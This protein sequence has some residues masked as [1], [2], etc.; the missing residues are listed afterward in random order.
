MW[1]SFSLAG[2]STRALSRSPRRRPARLV[3]GT[4]G[5]RGLPDARARQ[6]T[7]AFLAAGTDPTAVAQAADHHF[8]LAVT[9]PD[10][11]LA[12]MERDARVIGELAPY[13]RQAPG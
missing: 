9:G 1:T 5:P 13:I 10:V 7:D 2:S 4:I 3:T 8:P 6:L 11:L 12:T